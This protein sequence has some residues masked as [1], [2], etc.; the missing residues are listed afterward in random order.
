MNELTGDNLWCA[1]HG[2]VMPDANGNCPGCMDW[3]GEDDSDLWLD[4]ELGVS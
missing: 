4:D 3:T 1:A 2:Y